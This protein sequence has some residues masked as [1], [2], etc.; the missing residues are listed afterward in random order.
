MSKLIVMKDVFESEQEFE[1]FH[2]KYK[3]VL[4]NVPWNSST[5]SPVVLAKQ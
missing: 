2:S 5:A 4:S 1:F 3:G